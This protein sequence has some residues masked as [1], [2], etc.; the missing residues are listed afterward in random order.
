MNSGCIGTA[1]PLLVEA[2]GK[3]NAQING[4]QANLLWCPSF[5]NFPPALLA[6][7]Q[8]SKREAFFSSKRIAIQEWPFEAGTLTKYSHC[9][10]L[11]GLCS[12]WQSS[13]G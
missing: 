6:P 2:G 3:G 4:G 11:L 7:K 9:H 10:Q 13:C 8:S 5:L 12:H 1:L